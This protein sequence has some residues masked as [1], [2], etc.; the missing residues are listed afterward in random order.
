MKNIGQLPYSK[1]APE[2]EQIA[3]YHGLRLNRVSE[4][5]IALVIFSN[6]YY[7]APWESD[8]DP[9][10]HI[11][12]YEKKPITNTGL[13]LANRNASH[14]A[15]FLQKLKG[16]WLRRLFTKRKRK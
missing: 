13:Y 3:T 16:S 11:L 5:K 8:E 7:N 6:L 9:G 15:K 10:E 14:Y 4:Y 2:L 12:L 1:I